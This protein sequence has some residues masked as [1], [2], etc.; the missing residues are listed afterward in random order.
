MSKNTLI[1]NGKEI[2]VSSEEMRDFYE[3]HCD[4]MASALVNK[5]KQMRELTKTIRELRNE[6]EALKNRNKE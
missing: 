1:R 3:S 4:G 5:T 2:E 6:I